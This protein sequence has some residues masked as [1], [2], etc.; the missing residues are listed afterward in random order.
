MNSEQKLNII[1][2]FAEEIITEQELLSLFDKKKHPL[3]YDGF[4]PSGKIH[5][6]QSLYRKII[7]NKMEKAGIN[8]LLYLA[9]WHAYANNKL[10]GDLEKIRLA[11]EYFIEVW[12]S[13]GLT[14]VKYVWA[15]E[16]LQDSDYWKKVMQISAHTSIKRG[17]RCSQIIGRTEKEVQKISQLLYPVMQATD[18]FHMNI[19]IAQLGMDQRKVNVLAR[20]IG[21][22]FGRKPVAVHHHMLLGLQPPVNKE[23]LEKKIEMKMSKSNPNNAIFS[24]DTPE[25]IEKKIKKAYCPEKII[26][27][28]PVLEYAKYIIFEL[29]DKVKIERPQKFGGDI[30]YSSYS[31]LEQDF[32]K[33]NLHPV[34]LKQMVVKEISNAL[35]PVRKHF[36]K[37]RAKEIKEK[38][39]L[40]LRS[41]S[42]N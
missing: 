34:D 28:N 41:I 1:K 36:E 37:G 10:G 6:A 32:L 22:L 9:D 24:D 19:D 11:G 39:D 18:I 8:F 17:L 38:L 25:Q 23:G 2:S 42:K 4:E 13:L 30:E 35:K 29:K 21:H 33:G 16:I 40:S 31:A 27:D 20:E 7:I 14:N 26:E 5:I 3:A 15:H 12:K